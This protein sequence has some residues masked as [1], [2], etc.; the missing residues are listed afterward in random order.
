[1]PKPE[2]K[3]EQIKAKAHLAIH[4]LP[5]LPPNIKVQATSYGVAFT[6]TVPPREAAWAAARLQE[7]LGLSK[8]T[9]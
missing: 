3:A 4:K 9:P 5:K 8:E 6:V 1:M 2:N 7:W